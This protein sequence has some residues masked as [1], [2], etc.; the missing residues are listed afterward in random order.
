MV[1]TSTHTASPPSCRRASP[2]P[3]ML[4]SKAGLLLS[5]GCLSRSLTV[6]ISRRGFGAGPGIVSGDGSGTATVAGFGFPGR[7]RSLAG[8]LPLRPFFDGNSP[9][10]DVQPTRCGRQRPN[11]YD[12]QKYP[13]RG[14]ADRDSCK[15]VSGL[16]AERALAPQPAESPGQAAPLA[17][18]DQDQ[19]DQENR[20][21]QQDRK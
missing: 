12:A 8:G 21:E 1:R 10:T 4:S 9:S 5:S 14:H 16:G 19:Q 15:R 20:R 2:K 6:G 13:E 3:V 18:L 11:T 7:I 17:T